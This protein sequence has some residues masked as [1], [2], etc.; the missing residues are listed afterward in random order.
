MLGQGKARHGVEA[1]SRDGVRVG[2]G[3][4]G[5]APKGT[6]DFLALMRPPITGLPGARV[7][8]KAEQQDV[9]HG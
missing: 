9:A 2:G 4:L 7:T 8:Y 6:F 5:G 1:S 3:W